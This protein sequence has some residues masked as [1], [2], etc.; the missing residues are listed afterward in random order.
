MDKHLFDRIVQALLPEMGDT[1]ARRSLIDSAL[2]GSPIPD[3]IDWDGAARPFT[4]R[5]VRLLYD[6][7]ELDPGRSALAALLEEVR[8]QVGTDRQTQID[9]LLTD[10]KASPPTQSI[11]PP[12]T[13]TSRDRKTCFKRLGMPL[14]LSQ[15][16][17][18][19][20]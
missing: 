11:T 2:F 17:K 3:R 4:V 12:P 7:G 5:L 20:P 10:L 19:A 8:Q 13:E 14:A 1:D 9:A 16:T 15:H 18:I 6:Y